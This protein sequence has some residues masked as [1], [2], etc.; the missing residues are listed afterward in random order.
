MF[1]I[2]QT[3]RGVAFREEAKNHLVRTTHATRLTLRCL[4]KTLYEKVWIILAWLQT[5][6]NA[7]RAFYLSQIYGFILH[8]KS[9][10]KSHAQEMRSWLPGGK[11]SGPSLMARI[12]S[13]PKKALRSK[14]QSSAISSCLPRTSHSRKPL[15]RSRWTSTMWIA[16]KR[17]WATVLF[18]TCHSARHDSLWRLHQRQSTSRQEFRRSS[19]YTGQLEHYQRSYIILNCSLEKSW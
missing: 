19:T 9:S 6:H 5:E 15:D 1:M 11:S 3:R 4:G 7:I 10:V 8:Q 17:K 2:D 12:Q 16:D 14:L 13:L 18:V